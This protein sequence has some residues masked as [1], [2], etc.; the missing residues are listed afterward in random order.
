[1]LEYI[2][3]G[4]LC[5]NTLTGYDI[6]KCIEGGIGMFYRASY[7]SIYPIL[8]KLLEK[9]NAVC[10]D[11]PQGKR[12][13]KKYSITEGGKA[14]FMKWLNEEDSINSIE[15]FMAKVFFFDKLPRDIAYKKITVYEE[16]LQNYK[17][18]LVIKKDKYEKLENRD[19]FYFKLST[20]YFGICK[21][22]SILMWCDTV[23]LGNDLETLIS[24]V[25][26]EGM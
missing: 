15:S 6:R 20:L 23:K 21:L 10:V 16:K 2:I 4:T 22:Q 3:L 26:G 24:P 1:M 25:K 9:G 5:S 7:G 13:K 17:M 14:E 12:V 19:A 11:E 8:G 18:D